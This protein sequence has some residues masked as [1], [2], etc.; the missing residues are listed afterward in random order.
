MVT[1]QHE[2]SDELRKSAAALSLILYLSAFAL[3]V[4]LIVTSNAEADED[5]FSSTIEIESL[6]YSI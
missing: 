5:S 6:W 1:N 3:F 4:V 2:R